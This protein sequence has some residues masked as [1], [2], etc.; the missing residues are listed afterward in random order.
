MCVCV[1]VCAQRCISGQ[2]AIREQVPSKLFC[3][4][5]Y[6]VC[7]VYVCAYVCSCMRMCVL[8]LCGVCVCVCACVCINVQGVQHH[9]GYQG[10]EY[11]LQIRRHSAHRPGGT[12][13]PRQRGR[14]EDRDAC[15]R[16][17]QHVA[18]TQYTRVCIISGYL[19]AHTYIR[20]CVH[21]C[22]HIFIRTSIHTSTH[23][24][25]HS[26][27]HT[28]MHKSTHTHT[29]THASLSYAQGLGKGTVLD[30][31]APVVG[32]ISQ[33]SF[34]PDFHSTCFPML[35]FREFLTQPRQQPSCHRS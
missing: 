28:Y 22:T 19:C 14:E 1:Y 5:L 2:C 26:Y 31:A 32:K 16:A 20:T 29:G 17:R 15:A 33:K 34:C 12:R 13:N 25:A 9:F 11:L 24:Y 10:W 4:M 27:M 23:A 21:T 7:C 18:W 3:I 35:T 30:P 6:C 8:C